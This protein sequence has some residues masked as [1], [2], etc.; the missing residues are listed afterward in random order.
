[1]KPTTPTTPTA[2]K[3][4]PSDY[5]AGGEA[6]PRPTPSTTA[7]FENMTDK[8][9]KGP[10]PENTA[11]TDQDRALD[12]DKLAAEGFGDNHTQATAAA[13]TRPLGPQGW[14]R[15]SE[16]ETPLEWTRRA[17]DP[18][19]REQ[20]DVIGPRDEGDGN[21]IVGILCRRLDNGSGERTIL[22]F[23][24]WPGKLWTVYVEAVQP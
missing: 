24:W 19:A 13:Y 18:G 12:Q 16:G 20:W 21:R 2:P 14:P 3:N 10:E 6:F 5:R 7:D 11:D 1:M 4:R 9:S 15:P 8:Q 17:I 22:I 23:Q